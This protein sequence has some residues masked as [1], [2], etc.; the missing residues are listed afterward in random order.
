ML[1][2]IHR[3]FDFADFIFF[4]QEISEKQNE[5]QRAGEILII[6]EPY[7]MNFAMGIFSL[8]ISSEI[9]SSNIFSLQNYL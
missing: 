5:N 2:I 6:K 8:K 1:V 3:A 7:W 9:S 4:L